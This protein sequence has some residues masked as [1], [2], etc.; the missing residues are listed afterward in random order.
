MDDLLW[1]TIKTVF[2]KVCSWRGKKYES[3]ERVGAVAHC[4]FTACS[5]HVHYLYQL[6]SVRL[7]MGYITHMGGRERER[8][9]ERERARWRERDGR[10]EGGRKRE[11]ERERERE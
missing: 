3:F 6:K 9:R 5:L 1:K 11:R 10:R 7:T 8:E 2:G 4:M